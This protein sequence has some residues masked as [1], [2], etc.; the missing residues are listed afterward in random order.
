MRIIKKIQCYGWE[1]SSSKAVLLGNATSG[2]FINYSAEPEENDM[3]TRTGDEEEIRLTIC[4]AEDRRSCEPALKLL[5]VSLSRHNRNIPISLVYPHADECFI[6]WAKKINCRISVKTSRLSGSYS[7]NVK[8]QA[9]LELLQEGKQEVIW[10]DSDIVTTK[11]ILPTFSGLDPTT[12]AVS[13]EAL[14]GRRNETG[15]LRARLWGYRVKRIFPFSINTAVMR[16]TQSH[17]PLLE[18]WRTILESPEYKLAQKWEW[19]KRPIHM[20]G[21][22][23]V[24]TAL[25]S[26]DEF[27]VVPVKVL[28]RGIDIVQYFGPFGFTLLERTRCIFK[29]MPTFIHSQGSKPWMMRP[30]PQA[31][32]IKTFWTKCL[33]TYQDVSP[34]KH[35]AAKLTSDKPNRWT[36]PSSRAGAIFRYAGGNYP[37]VVGL[38]LALAFDL[39][40]GLKALKKITKRALNRWYPDAIYTI[41]AA[42]M[43]LQFHRNLFARQMIMKSRIYGTSAPVVLHGP[44]AGM[45]YINEVVWGPIEPKWI[46]TYEMEL[47]TI[48]R[49][50]AQENY[51]TIIDVGSAEGYYAVGL[52]IKL[53]AA[54][55][56]SYD[57]DPWA[58]AQQRRLALLNEVKNLTVGKSCNHMELAKQISNKTLII[59]DIEGHEYDLLDPVVVPKLRTCDILIELHEYRD[60]GFTPLSGAAEFLRRF[61]SSHEITK[62]QVASRA[63]IALDRPEIK[64]DQDELAE[65]LNERRM[66]DAIWLW[67]KSRA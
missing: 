32:K 31:K 22:Q 29:G 56:Y 62:V 19:N 38:P 10:I 28:R 2:V 13:E 41:R 66:P 16:V 18:K 60:Y 37:P 50:F 30:E 54:K 59:C 58:R 3:K 9:L 7:W 55:L 20:V 25:L 27:D 64:L 26:S 46:G 53:N 35:Y 34:Y 4:I 40:R 6:D 15:G 49:G 67:L 12:I 65:M 45:K 5:L 39:L 48:V 17:I 63:N 51:S 52:A 33:I 11:D 36:A 44:F 8:P 61:A 1:R 47:E 14:W 23:D 42:R 57:T 24:L 21:D 43:R